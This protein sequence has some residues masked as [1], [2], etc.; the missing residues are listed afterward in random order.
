MFCPS[1]RKSQITTTLLLQWNIFLISPRRGGELFTEPCSS[2]V[3]T[4]QRCKICRALDWVPYWTA[5]PKCSL[6]PQLAPSGERGGGRIYCWWTQ[7]QQPR[8]GLLAS[9]RHS[10]MH[11][12]TGKSLLR[13]SSCAGR[14]GSHGPW[15]LEGRILA[16]DCLFLTSFVSP[17]QPARCSQPWLPLVYIEI[18]LVFMHTLKIIENDASTVLISVSGT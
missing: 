12:F 9:P 11:S 1:P 14:E 5:S 2:P 7:H 15:G 16:S 4:A 13:A 3:F 8:E 10:F 18:I 6:H 17:W